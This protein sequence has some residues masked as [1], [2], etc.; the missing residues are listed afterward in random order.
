[1]PRELIQLIKT[2]A[3]A[4]DANP[5]PVTTKKIILKLYRNEEKDH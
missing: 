2:V 4:V 1:M 5:K 3:T